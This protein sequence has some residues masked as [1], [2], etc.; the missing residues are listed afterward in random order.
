M[1]ERF[2]VNE[3]RLE[4]LR[5]L[6]ADARI[7]KRKMSSKQHKEYINLKAAYNGFA[8]DYDLQQTLRVIDH[9]E[10]LKLTESAT[11]ADLI[12]LAVLKDKILDDE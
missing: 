1:A 3:N 10:T 5:E 7:G 9:I 4:H 2:N 12:R 6:M 8:K 11:S